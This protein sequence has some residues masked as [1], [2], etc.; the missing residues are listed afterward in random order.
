ML[1]IGK[2]AAGHADYYLEQA[3]WP[4][5]RARAVSS[6]VED[7]YLDGPEAGGEWIGGGGALVGLRGE[8]DGDALHR[9]LV[10]EHPA[11]GLALSRRGAGRVPGFDVTFSAPKS[12]SVLFGIGDERLRATIREAHD[13]AVVEAF[14]YLEREAAVTRRGA[15]GLHAIPGRGLVA[16]AFR[17]RTSR[18]ADPQL[19][20]HVLVANVTL[21][22]D[23]RWSALDGRRLYAHGKTAGYLY[24]ARLRAEL[25]RRLCVEWTPVRNGIADIVG[26]P[27]GVL[28]AFSRRRAQIEDELERRGTRSPAAAQVAALET[29]RRKDHRV[30]SQQLVPE[31]RDRAAA[32]GLTSEGINQLLGRA[33]VPAFDAA[34]EERIAERLGS[35]GGLTRQRSTF[36]RR[37]VI[38]AFCAELPTGTDATTEQI[39]AAA[40]RFL[41][42]DRAVVLAVGERRRSRSDVLRRRDG[43]LVDM[44]RSERVYSTPELLALEQR[45][46]ERASDGRGVGAGVVPGDVVE[47]GIVARPTLA[48]EQARMVRRLTTDRDAVAVVVGQAGTGKTF[49]LAAAREA[50]EASG[51]TVVGAALARRAARELEVGAGIPSTSVAALVDRL[52][53]RPATTLPR[54]AVL[55]V[56]E[57]GMVSTR[58]LAELAQHAGHAQAKLVLVGDHHQLPEIDAGGAFRALAT[59]LPAI[60]LTENRRQAARWERDALALL[61]DGDIR[62]ALDSY[63]RHGRVVAGD[64]SEH[65]RARLVADWWRTNDPEGAVMIAFRRAD[66][67]DLNGR[68]RALMRAAR[69]LGDVEIALPGGSF[70]AGDRVVLRRNDRRLGVANGD[71][72]I[73]THVDQDARAIDVQIADRVYG[74]TPSTSAGPAAA[75][76]PRSRTDTPSPGTPRRDSRATRRSCS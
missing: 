20:T 58:E 21:G 29:R 70:A 62:A 74:S 23:G 40:D 72:G 14:G 1:S 6:G 42:S 53:A 28:R 22:A 18:A 2:L 50:W 25:T 54:R 56:D 15:G 31:W 35:A 76:G 65:V 24:E 51:H 43:R 71:R 46:L 17:H 57:A 16:A 69:A 47:R 27:S 7:Y 39:E 8:V 66:V 4:V 19:H 32:L 5:T 63:E 61:R 3:H 55:V 48:D 34:M 33:A 45:L 36:T 75:P 11:S 30:S 12:A 41:R 59:R 60:E 37:D 44:V 67:A 26:V 10:G 52:R 64:S 13:Q 49:A 73:V 38:Q 9:V 68:A